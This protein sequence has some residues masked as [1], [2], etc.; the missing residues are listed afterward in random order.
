MR[1]SCMTRKQK[2]DLFR[3]LLAGA[4]FVAAFFLPL[5]GWWKGLAFA[6]PYL[7][8]GF[9]VLRSAFLSLLQGQ[10]MNETFLMTVASLGAFALGEFAE[11]VAVMLFSAVG[12][13]FESYAVGKSRNSVVELMTLCPEEAVVLRDGEWVTVSPEE[14]RVGE[15]IRVLPGEKIPLDGTVTEGISSL[16]T[17]SL[18]GESLPRDVAPGDGVLSGCVNLSGLLILRAE[19][20]F[21]E[22]TAA[23]ILALVEDSAANRSR[24]E[25]FVASF[26]RWYTPV[27]LCAALAVGLIPSL[28]TGAWSVWI[29]RALEFL[30]VSCPCAIVISV[31]LTYFGAIGGA[32]RK[33]ILV[34][35]SD[36]LEALAK[37]ETVVFDKTGTL[38][39]GV[40]EVV[41]AEGNAPEVLLET[42]ALCEQFSNHPIA[43]SLREGRGKD[44]DESRVS[45]FEEISGCGVH[46]FVDGRECFV[47]K[48]EWMT[49]M[50]FPAPTPSLAGTHIY[51]VL[52]GETLGVITISDQ[53]KPN[54]KDSLARLRRLGIRRTV[55]LTG[56]GDSAAKAVALQAGVDEYRAELL[57]QD[58]VETL[59]PFLA[60]PGTTVF[61]GDG[62][63][64][65]PVLASAD[66]GVAMGAIGSDA[67]IEAADVVLMHD[68]L[69]ALPTVIS[70]A[71]KTHG[72]VLEN[73]IFSIGIKVAVMILCALG[74]TDMWYAVFADV[75]VSV[76]AILN[77][78]RTL[79]KKD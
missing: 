52:E 15:S 5:T 7:I 43:R 14:I 57:P 2:R 48:R 36:R 11:G 47:G 77:A 30:V 74:I 63:N 62:M 39:K 13:L 45:G 9:P 53:L 12:E 58:K 71:R 66:V 46:A 68:D 24:S 4:C 21:E 76:L 1:D 49:Q 60:E 72:I 35:G 8:V 20:E 10:W 42:A 56:D 32:S 19:R 64:D 69:S 3:I 41:N 38:T 51:V 44:C 59:K 79:S 17:R 50:G 33:G 67:A 78:M 18:T 40:F 75:G 61:V 34:K 23:K 29:Y 65:A 25:T 28:I 22:S 37:A 31:P 27:V 26:A 6:V 16:D 54:A 55:M 70:L 73:L